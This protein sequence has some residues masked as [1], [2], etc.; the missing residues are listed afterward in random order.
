MPNPWLK[1]PAI[2][3]IVA[4]FVAAIRAKRDFPQRLA[5][6]IGS[7]ADRM[8]K[9]EA[10]AL[11]AWA[12]ALAPDDGYVRHVTAGII[13]RQVPAWHWGIARDE[14]RNLAYDRAIRNSVTSDSV[15]LE[16]GTGTGILAMMAARAGARHVY[17]IEI[18]PV[19]ADAARANIAANG[20]ADK[21]T[22]ITADAMTV[23]AGDQ[24][25]GR[26]NL[27]LH[28]IIAN[29]LLSEDV[30]KLTAHARAELL[31]EEAVHLPNTIWATGQL[32][33]LC[34]KQSRQPLGE[35]AGF[36]LSAIDMLIPPA[37]LGKGP[38]KDF[39]PLSQPRQLIRF[40]LSG[41]TPHPPLD[42]FCEMQIDQAGL[43][44]H[45]FQWIGFEFPDGTRFENPPT[46]ASSWAVRLW[47]MAP[48]QVAVGD[49]LLLRA[50]HDA[51]TLMVFV[52]DS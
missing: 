15:V 42:V 14:R 50:R 9:G 10:V 34:V 18:V 12:R 37:A 47:D 35:Q 7:L 44:T 8:E 26:C 46:V 20:Y 17:T 30:L 29:D 39:R 4:P 19:I 49:T 2:P 48:R 41:R 3:P 45:I 24:L 23:K 21:I 22:V 38:L 31:T 28:E 40:D 27:F 16:I 36:D 5:T 32:A 33:N 51:T 25:P 6:L 1:E 13:G 43:A 52:V 11:S